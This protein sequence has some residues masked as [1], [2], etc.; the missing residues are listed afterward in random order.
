MQGMGGN[1]LVQRMIGAARL[2]V[3]TYE[4]IEH[5]EGATPQA[6]IVVVIVSLATAIG[7][8]GND[9]ATAGFV[10]GLISSL[11]GW[12]IGAAL[13][14]FVGTRLLAGAATQAT[15][16]QVLRTMGFAST[17]GILSVFGFI[18]FVG[19]IIAFIGPVLVMVATFI[20]IRQS[21]D[22]STGRAAAVAVAAI[23]VQIIVAAILALIFGVAVSI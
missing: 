20:A 9:D 8:L 3:P 11:L 17:A 5:D 12:V 19:P 6:A 21:L 4:E 2:D 22:I 15:L 7:S 10:S 1:S 14:Y 16:G 18:T 23:V 13:V